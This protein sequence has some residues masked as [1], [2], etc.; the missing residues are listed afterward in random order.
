MKH[1]IISGPT[2]TIG[3]ALIKKC[4]SE[5]I[6]VT[7]V[8]HRE[9]K[10]IPTFLGENSK[11]IRIVKCDL[12]EI[13][14]LPNYLANSDNESDVYGGK[15]IAIWKENRYDV[16]YHF[17]WACTFGENRNNIDAQIENI[18]YTCDSIEAAVR[19]GCKRFVGAGSQAEYG[20][21][22]A[23]LSSDIPCFP[24][25][26][27]G[28]AKL[29]AGRL[30]RIK[31]EQLGIEFI[32]TR[33]LSIYGPYDGAN[34]LVS[35]VINKL[36]NGEHVATTKG[37]QI[38]DYLYSDDA[39]NAMY[40]LGEGGKNGRIY[41]IGSGIAK[42][43]KEYI[44]IIVN[45]VKNKISNNRLENEDGGFA[46]D[47]AYGEIEYSPNQVMHLEADISLLS[48]DTGFSPAISFEEGIRR[49]ILQ[50]NE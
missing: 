25:N 15:D 30:G 12:N 22:D 47:I 19:L 16:F 17:A 35:S 18:K 36:L 29:A 34:T 9:S 10:R 3:M 5:G 27:Y 37:E 40:L 31:A 8:C 39:A 7:A 46:P 24:E 43:L 28:I 44:E 50:C 13:K 26:A 2:G 33:I 41:V 45:E 4:I 11:Y 32:W 1:V 14:N 38:W 48:E 6:Y 21:S 20:R 42:P 49:I 23:P